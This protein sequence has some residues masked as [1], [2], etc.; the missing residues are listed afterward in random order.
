MK[1][2][3]VSVLGLAI[4]LLPM[5]VF[6][7]PGDVP[8]PDTV[9]EAAV[10]AEIGDDG[11]SGAVDSTLLL[12]L[13][14][15]GGLDDFPNQLVTGVTDLTGLEAATNLE[16][17]LL[18]NG[19]IDSLEPV[20][21]LPALT[22]LALFDM[23]VEDADVAE[24]AAGTAEPVALL[25]SNL[26]T[27][28]PNDLTTTGINS[29]GQIGSIVELSLSGL[30][31]E[32]DISGLSTLSLG[33]LGFGLGLSM[34]GNTIVDGFEV[35]A[36]F[37]G[38]TALSL[39]QT[40][41]TSADLD[42][43]DWS[44]MTSL[45]EL[46]LPFNAITDISML[47]DLGAPS[48]AIIDLAG[49][50]LDNAA[51]CTHIPALV[52]AGYTVLDGQVL[53][54][55]SPVL[56]LTLNGVG[57]INP[58]PGEY[59]YEVGTEVFL[60]ANQISGGGVFSHWTG[61]VADPS[62]PNTS[63]VMNADEAVEAVF[64]DGDYTLTIQYAGDGTG[65]TSPPAGVWA[66]QDGAS[67]GLNF[68]PDPG[69]FWGGWQGDLTGIIANTIIMDSDKTVTAVFGA[70]GYDLIIG[71]NDT[72][73]GFTFPVM[74]TYPL[75]TGTVV[76]INA[77][78]DFSEPTY[79]F[80]EWTGDIGT[81]DP[82]NPELQVTM[83][84]ARTV[85][86][87]FRKPELTISITGEGTTNPVPGVYPYDNGA[88]AAVTATPADGWFFVGWQGDAEGAG[89]LNILMDGD[90][91]VTAVFEQIPVYTLTINAADG[92][93]TNPPAGSYPYDEGAVVEITA[94]PETGWQFLR[95]E[96]D[97]TSTD[98]STLVNMDGDKT[99]T[100]VFEILSYDV[101][102]NVVGNGTT[103]PAAG[104]SPWDY[105]SVVMITATPATGW[106]FVRWEGDFSVP[107]PEVPNFAEV[108]VDGPKTVTAVFEQI[109]YTLTIS[110]AGDGTTDPPTG[111]V[112]TSGTPVTITAQP[113]DGWNFARWEGDVS[114][115]ESTLSFTMDSD[116]SVTA[117]FEEQIIEGE[118]ET[119]V[120]GEGEAPVEGEGEEPIEGEGEEPVEGE[121]EE[122]VE[123]EGEE[124]VEGEGEEPVEGEGE[125]PVEGEGEEPVEGE[126][127]EPVEGEGEEPV[128]GEGEEPVEGEGEEPVEGEG[129]EPVEGE[130]EEPVEGE[131]EE[132]V[133]GEGE[134]PVEGEGEAPVEG[135][136]E[137]PVE[138]EGEEPVEG[139]GEAP[140]EG[141][142]EEPVEG[143]GEEP[144][145][146]EGE[147]PVEGEGE[148]PVEGEGE[149]EEEACG[150][151]QQNEKAL[152]IKEMVEK[153]LGDW[154]LIGVSLL[155]LTALA[156]MRK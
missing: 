56:T 50:P 119:P 93:S 19:D 115:T 67:V 59:R 49:N 121:G 139:E 122:P 4:C 137:E 120:E 151:C 55:G 143:E 66:Y 112:Y 77:I 52:T 129:E 53:P 9:L 147:E 11:V 32:F 7:A 58:A 37:T 41:I 26:G 48:G 79:I 14:Q 108:E 102:I 128:E 18:L 109:T 97:V 149:G 135:E 132:P 74:G 110:V 103:L 69:N 90:K 44:L 28:T 123:G 153:S 116:I 42:L 80:G 45:G 10:E 86:A 3:L 1:K 62:N 104:T 72:D 84:Q 6:A 61:D 127:E 154:L 152:T 8:M 46:L 71:V 88:F 27:G 117:V 140:V 150:C 85:T 126:G 20:A 96:G 47:L 113:A 145:E 76:D 144:V 156:G 99:V 142:G 60:N 106:Q 138:G 23:G 21:D 75:A 57:E 89:E 87:N 17:L 39:G 83:D 73:L 65:V 64:V 155:G 68:T 130:G 105:G 24:L 82:A 43:V 54:C 95:W 101:T 107:N 148:T 13:V 94:T 114:G 30:G 51:V 118:G 29:I 125:E 12:N 22:G 35:I 133:E 136:G 25:I 36:G 31:N 141:E 70:T 33:D 131:G 2:I 63:I 92:G 91:A 98:P 34:D 124:P 38:L 16:F 81:A 5:A 146:G 15:L 100:P 111:G 78:V 40:G 134:E